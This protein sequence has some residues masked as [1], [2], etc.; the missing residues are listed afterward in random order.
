MYFFCTS[1]VKCCEAW[2]ELTSG[3]PRLR[4]RGYCSSLLHIFTLSRNPWSNWDIAQWGLRPSSVLETTKHFTQPRPGVLRFSS[5]SEAGT[6]AVRGQPSATTIGEGL[7]HPAVESGVTPNRDAEAACAPTDRLPESP[8]RGKPQAEQSSSEQQK[9]GNGDGGGG[10]GGGSGVSWIA[11]VASSVGV[12]TPAAKPPLSAPSEDAGK[13][14][15]D[16]GGLDWIEDLVTTVKG[17]SA[18]PHE[19][20]APAGGP[21]T[22]KCGTAAAEGGGLS[23]ATA[24]SGPTSFPDFSTPPSAHL[25]TAATA[26]IPVAGPQADASRGGGPA[27]TT[28]GKQIARPPL[29]TTPSHLAWKPITDGSAS[30]PWGAPPPDEEEGKVKKDDSGQDGVVQEN[31][32]QQRQQQ[33]QQQQQQPQQQK[34]FKSPPKLSRSLVAPQE[35]PPFNSAAGSTANSADTKASSSDPPARQDTAAVSGASSGQETGGGGEQRPPSSGGDPAAGEV[36]GEKLAPG[37][38]ARTPGD[39]H[40]PS[41]GGGTAGATTASGGSQD[42]GGDALQDDIKNCG[43]KDQRAPEALPPLQ[44]KAAATGGGDGGGSPTRWEILR[45]SVQRR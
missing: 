20:S 25:T 22:R 2:C 14:P 42:P 45:S 18:S 36:G 32:Q 21:D 19:P 26:P 23:W 44:E 4:G 39:Q 34:R 40:A 13:P 1:F 15:G 31:P 3:R 6:G 33:Q 35:S 11:E 9:E 37:S 28:P 29:A 8:A 17:S 38:D 43:S 10:D 16:G 41:A 30:R 5:L 12:P 7:P 24:S 27:P